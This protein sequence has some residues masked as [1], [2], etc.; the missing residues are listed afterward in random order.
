MFAIRRY[1]ICKNLNQ[2]LFCTFVRL[3]MISPHSINQILQTVPIEDIVGDYVNLK[4]SGSRYKGNCPFHDEKTPSFTVTPNLNIYKCFGCQK[5]GNS[6]QFLMEI[7]QLSF[8]EAARELAKRFGIELIE[9]ETDNRDEAMQLQREKESLQAL[10]EFATQFFESQLHDSEEG[11][12][13]ALPY[14]RERGYSQETIKHWRLGFSPSNWTAFYDHAK[15][16]GYADEL[17]ISAGLIKLRDKD[18]S[19]YDLFRNRVM[20]PLIAVSGKTIGFAGR[21]MGKV[22]KAPKYV[23]SPETQLYKKSDFLFAVF[24][25]KNSIRKEDK[26]YLMEGYTDVITL[27]Q[28]GIE[29]CVASSGTALTPGQIRLLKRFTD[30]ATAIYDGDAAGIKASLRGIDLLLEE[31]MNVRVVAMPE[32]QDPDS[33]CKELGPEAFKEYLAKNEENFILFK[34]KLLFQESGSD[35]IK[36]SEALRDILE[37]VALIKDALKRD[38]LVREIE[39]VCDTQAAVLYQEL[40]KIRKKKLFDEGKSLIREVNQ[41]IDAQEQPFTKQY[42]LNDL[43]QEQALIYILIKYGSHQIGEERAVDLIMREYLAEEHLSFN[44][45]ETIPVM[46]ELIALYESE[47]DWPKDEEWIQHENLEIAALA[48]SIFTEQHILSPRFEQ[49][50]IYVKSESENLLDMIK[51]VFLNLNRTK[52]DN[53]I[54]AEQEKLKNPEED[55]ETVLIMLDLLNQK[56][57][58]IN[59]ILGAVVSRI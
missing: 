19:Q 51:E 18:N 12:N 47:S 52:I 24:Q 33:Y 36:R 23:N 53:I 39:R 31:G 59:N 9:T 20:F 27:H 40:A 1:G 25:A 21:I 41:L 13:V 55:P 6:I 56:K 38:A 48:A 54:F 44:N 16:A 42:V 2:E 11:R 14:F 26:A 28:A 17:L 8:V 5:G 4:R 49:S 3:S 35:P 7:E 29:N 22:D 30:N 34:A 46:R 50:M 37:S 32:G 10:N 15:K 43:S 45:P 58:E 57:V